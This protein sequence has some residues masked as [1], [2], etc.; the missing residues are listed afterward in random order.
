MD[1]K[2]GHGKGILVQNHGDSSRSVAHLAK[3]LDPGTR[4]WP[5]CLQNCAAMTLMVSE[6]RKLMAG[7]SLIVGILHQV[8]ILLSQRVSKWMT[9][10]WLLQYETG[11]M[12]QEDLQIGSRE[13]LNPASCLT[14][15]KGR[16]LKEAYDCI[17]VINRSAYPKKILNFPPLN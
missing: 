6:I 7:E 8:K 5:H 17:Q 13:G 1:V 9:S 11:L 16:D 15:P 14:S 2:Q 4:V 3:M 12:E 10:A